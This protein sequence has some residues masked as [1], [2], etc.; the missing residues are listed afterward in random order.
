ML[1]N[2]IIAAAAPSM[3]MSDLNLMSTEIQTVIVNILSFICAFILRAR[4]VKSI[5]ASGTGKSE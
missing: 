2:I 3:I 1:G 4:I 5:R